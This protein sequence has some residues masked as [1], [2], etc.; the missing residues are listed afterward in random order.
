MADKDDL[1]A[2]ILGSNARRT[3]IQLVIASIFVGAIL[4][5]LGVG[6]LDFW[7]GLFDGV[8][9]AVG[10]IGENIGEV[11]LTL[12]TYFLLG[13]AIVAPIWVISRLLRSGGSKKR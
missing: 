11:A 2:R 12:I 9:D 6:A 3:I 1:K 10:A 8:K 7:R 5:F 4:S 13:A